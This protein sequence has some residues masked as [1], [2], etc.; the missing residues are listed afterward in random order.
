MS[1][2]AV[3][4]D[5]DG[6]LNRERGKYTYLLSDFEWV[7]DVFEALKILRDKGYMFFIISNQGGISKKIYDKEAVMEIDKKIV[8]DLAAEGIQITAS[9]Y[10]PHHSA[11]EKCLCRKPRSL[12]L[13]RAVARYDID[14]S[15]SWF[16]GDST[17]DMIAGQRIGI[18]GV[19]N[20]AN[21]SLLNVV[22]YI[23]D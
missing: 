4:L 13:E 1:N 3:F 5:R 9:Y 15:K 8:S 19:F 11:I 21:E 22:K 7:P 10:C 6:V 18:K 14:V 17:R 23:S 20:R 12:M 2:K 16:I